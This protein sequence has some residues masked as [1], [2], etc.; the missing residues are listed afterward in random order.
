MC[1]TGITFVDKVQQSN[2]IVKPVSG[3]SE[4]FVYQGMFLY[5]LNLFC[6]Q[7]NH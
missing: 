6:I 4:K 3:I 1:S 7:V 5:I 2:A